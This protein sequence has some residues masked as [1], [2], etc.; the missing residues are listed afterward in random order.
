MYVKCIV[1]VILFF[2]IIFFI[3]FLFYK[4]LF[5]FNY[6]NYFLINLLLTITYFYTKYNQI[7]LTNS[8]FSR[9]N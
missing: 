2:K 9:L 6:I 3:F 8:L 5:I 7:I 1:D 4:I